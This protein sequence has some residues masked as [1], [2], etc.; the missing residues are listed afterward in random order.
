M[1]ESRSQPRGLNSPSS[2]TSRAKK[3]RKK[4]I[5]QVRDR[6]GQKMINRIKAIVLICI[7]LLSFAYMIYS[8]GSTGGFVLLVIGLVC[9]LLGVLYIREG[10][11]SG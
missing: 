2:V 5:Q 8:G 6:S 7:A 1:K 11:K 3:N 10:K 4:N 9:G